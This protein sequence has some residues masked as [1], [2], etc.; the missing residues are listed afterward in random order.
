MHARLD[1]MAAARANKRKEHGLKLRVVQHKY[2]AQ[3]AAHVRKGVII[4]V[5]VSEV[6]A[7]CGGGRGVD[8]GVQALELALLTFEC[9]Y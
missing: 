5:M 4:T 9:A 6:G 1:D 8:L 7:C 2:A 3:I